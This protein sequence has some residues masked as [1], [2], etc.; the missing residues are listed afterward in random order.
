MQAFIISSLSSHSGKTS[1][2]IGLARDLTRRGFAV[3][4]CKFGPDY[5]DGQFLTH[6]SG[7]P[8]YNLDILAMPQPRMDGIL[9]QICQNKDIL[10]IEGALGLF[11]KSLNQ[12]NATADLARQYNIPVIIIAD[13]R[14]SAGTTAQI[15]Y[16]I[17]KTHPDL[18]IQCAI[19]N[20]VKTD[21]H[22]QLITEQHPHNM[23]IGFLPPMENPLESRHLG[24]VL[25]GELPKIEEQIEQMADWVAQ[26][27]GPRVLEGVMGHE[28]TPPVAPLQPILPPPANNIAIARDNCFAFIY[29]HQILEW[30]RAGVQLH[31]FSPLA[32]EAPPAICLFVFLPG[33]YPEL[34]AEQL[35]KC[36]NFFEKLQQMA[37]DGSI[38]YGECGGYMVLGEELTDKNGLSHKMAGLLP[39]ITDFSTR[40]LHL[41]YQ[42]LNMNPKLPV[43]GGYNTILTHEFHYSRLVKN[44]ANPMA[45]N[46]Q[47]QPIGSHH[48]LVFGSYHHII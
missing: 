20:R 6:A 4:C 19:Y 37:N 21:R 30:V 32:N 7:N 48:G 31:F 33:G 1:L 36:P 9:H 43:W 35:S 15:I 24:L 16:A 29:N 38:I 2:S 25:A 27:L 13:A 45:T 34:Y 8:C 22:R 47:N 44:T 28:F 42:Y 5:I 11:D 10:L 39:V 3:Q 41:Q 23:A 18:N 17:Q 14:H 12:P 26:N 40:Q 46:Q